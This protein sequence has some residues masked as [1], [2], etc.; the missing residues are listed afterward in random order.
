MCLQVIELL[1][2]ENA[3]ISTK[4]MSKIQELLQN[5]H[6][7]ES[8]AEAEAEEAKNGNALIEETSALKT[9]DL[10]AEDQSEQREADKQAAAK[11]SAKP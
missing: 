2:K 3:E 1:G 4:Q 9:E 7:I 8:E 10:S 11:E 5:E 6:E